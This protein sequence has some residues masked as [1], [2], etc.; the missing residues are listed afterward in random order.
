MKVKAEV[1]EKIPTGPM[2]MAG[3][4]VERIT[5]LRLTRVGR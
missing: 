4:N 3:K 2:K 5:V 1:D